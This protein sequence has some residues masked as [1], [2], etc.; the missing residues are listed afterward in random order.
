MLGE[1]RVP[2]VPR[3]PV[4]LA[5]HWPLTPPELEAMADITKRRC[6]RTILSADLDGDRVV[7]TV[8][9]IGTDEAPEALAVR[10]KSRSVGRYGR[11]GEKVAA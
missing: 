3:R 7:L 1:R 2:D 4:R 6:V 11:Q 9:W 10:P 5:H 8:E